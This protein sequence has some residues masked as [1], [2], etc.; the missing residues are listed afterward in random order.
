MSFRRASVRGHRPRAGTPASAAWSVVVGE[1]GRGVA[2]IRLLS[3]AAVC[4]EEIIDDAHA[5]LLCDDAQFSHTCERH[6][7]DELTQHQLKVEIV[8][9]VA[10]FVALQDFREGFAVLVDDPRP[11]GASGA[12]TVA[13]FTGFGGA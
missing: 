1:W 12:G 13:A 5:V 10:G 4:G 7:P 11:Q 8:E 9:F 2:R 6:R 3:A